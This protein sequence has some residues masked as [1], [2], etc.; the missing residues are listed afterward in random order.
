MDLRLTFSKL[1]DLVL[2]SSPRN[3]S[4]AKVVPIS[5]QAEN[6]RGMFED[7]RSH[8][9]FNGKLVEVF[10]LQLVNHKFHLK[11]GE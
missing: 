10:A 9:N 11:D 5:A 1:G 3:H 4:T 6:I 7:Q 8:G 2:D